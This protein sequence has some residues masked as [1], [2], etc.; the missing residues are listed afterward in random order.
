MTLINWTA[1]ATLAAL[2]LYL[3]MGVR[4]AGARR[5][6]KIDAPA[7]TGDPM[8]ERHFR[9]QM[10]TLEWLPV[11]LAAL[12]LCAFYWGDRI[13]AIAGAVWVVGR[14]FYMIGYVS[15]PRARRIGF[16]IQWLA[17]MFLM[18]G[19]AWGAIRAI[20]VTG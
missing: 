20:M 8:F 6:Y 16:L 12:W 15:D 13:A 18:A 3:V 19:A 10:N 9:V 2:G 17:V 4:V 7:T 14:F 5:K 1:L 11:F